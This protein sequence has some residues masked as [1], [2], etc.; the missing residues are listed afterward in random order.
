MIILSRGRRALGVAALVGSLVAS[1]AAARANTPHTVPGPPTGEHVTTATSTSFTVVMDRATNTTSYRV[2]ASTI[3]SDIYLANINKPSTHRKIASAATPTIVSGGWGYTYVPFYYR[4]ATVNGSSVRWSGDYHSTYLRSVAP[5]SLA[6]HMDGTGNYL[7]WASPRTNGYNIE[8]AT[9]SA[10][11]TGVLNFTTTDDS[12][13]F[14]PSGMSVGRTYYV[15]VRG[16]N[17]P[18]SSAWSNVTTGVSQTVGHGLDVLT[19]NVLSTTFDGT[20]ESGNTIAPWSQRVAGPNG[21]SGL[22]AEAGA[23]VN[24]VQEAGGLVTRAGVNHP[25]VD[26]I[27]DALG[28]G[29]LLA[30]T[31]S[32]PNGFNRYTG[33]YLIYRPSLVTPVGAG[34]YWVL[35][36]TKIAVY[37]VFQNLYGSKFLAV[38]FHLDPHTGGTYDQTRKQE[39]DEI[40]ADATAYVTDQGP[41]PIVYSGDT[42]SWPNRV[43]ITA[44]TPGA[45]MRADGYSETNGAAQVHHNW[46]YESINSY[47]WTPPLGGSAD[48]TFVSPGIVVN[49]WLEKLHTSGGQFVRPVIPSDHNPVIST[50]RLTVPITG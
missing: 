44:D 23:A 5:T 34:G 3:A 4:V 22:I 47:M 17:G 8:L 6:A 43:G 46:A 48:R 42:N 19:Y 20:V 41:M 21:V 9:N 28:S 12:H 11:T 7:T 13:F 29:Y 50:I 1:A 35:S 39:I 49:T 33:N 36:D 32:G 14:T 25:Q 24:A 30:D 15:R 40:I 2:A 18:W 45:E 16:Q 10:F 31:T 26:D 37:Q 27:V 38:S